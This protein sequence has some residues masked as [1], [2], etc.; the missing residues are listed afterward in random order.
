MKCVRSDCSENDGKIL[1]GVIK[2]LLRK[3]VS[4]CVFSENIKL[5]RER[6]NKI[7]LPSGLESQ[8]MGIIKKR[9]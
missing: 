9:K 3:C 2:K 7:L 6:E 1:R 8:P 5:E 4:A